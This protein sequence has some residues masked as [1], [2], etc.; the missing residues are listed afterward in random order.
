M[1]TWNADCKVFVSR[2]NVH[3]NDA[4]EKSNDKRRSILVRC[5]TDLQRSTSD[6]PVKWTRTVLAKCAFFV[7]MPRPLRE[8]V[9]SMM[10]QMLTVW[11]LLRNTYLL[12]LLRLHVSCPPSASQSAEWWCCTNFICI[13]CII[14]RPSYRPHHASCG[15]PV[16]LSVRLSRTGL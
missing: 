4:S 8:T 5:L 16:R 14:M 6:R 2:I 3:G 10:S 9:Y 7:A 12:L 15:L 11:L 1:L 13:Y